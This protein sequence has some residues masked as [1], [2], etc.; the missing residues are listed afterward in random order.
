V[1][2]R[3]SPGLC[4]LSLCGGWRNNEQA[5]EFKCMWLVI[6]GTGYSGCRSIARYFAAQIRVD[7]VYLCAFSIRTTLGNNT[8]A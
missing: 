7:C 6:E 5:E 3:S 2:T 1:S 4:V 8:T